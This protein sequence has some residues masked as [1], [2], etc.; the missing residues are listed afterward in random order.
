MGNAGRLSSGTTASAASFTAAAAADTLLRRGVDE[1]SRLADVVE[2]LEAT[3][4]DRP[5]RGVDLREL[6]MAG[7]QQ[8]RGEDQ[9]GARKAQQWR[10]SG[11]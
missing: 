11:R 7:K 4:E 1:V 6:G 9:V 3:D 2:T 10:P 8:K 5:R